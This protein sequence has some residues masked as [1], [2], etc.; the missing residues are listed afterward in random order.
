[1]EKPNTPQFLRQ[2][3]LFITIFSIVPQCN[4]IHLTLCYRIGPRLQRGG[5]VGKDFFSMGMTN[6]HSISVNTELEQKSEDFPQMDETV[7]IEAHGMSYRTADNKEKWLN[8]WIHLKIKSTVRIG[9]IMFSGI[10]RHVRTHENA[11]IGQFVTDNICGVPKTDGVSTALPSQIVP[12]AGASESEPL[13]GYFSSRNGILIER[14]FNK[15][16][17]FNY[18]FCSYLTDLFTLPIG[19]KTG[20]KEINRMFRLVT[21]LL[22]ICI[23]SLQILCVIIRD[24]FHSGEIL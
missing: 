15:H 10:Q 12:C 2:F 19:S 16:F 21:F 3:A 1:M 20:S 17:N 5:V 14:V 4:N 23:G 9:A 24:K 6:F 11:I 18:P 13:V 8:G 22:F 7:K